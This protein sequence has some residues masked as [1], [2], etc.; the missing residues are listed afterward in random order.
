MQVHLSRNYISIVISPSNYTSPPSTAATFLVTHLMMV[1]QPSGYSVFHSGDTSYWT[2]SLVFNDNTPNQY[3]LPSQTSSYSLKLWP[4][5]R[6]MA[7]HISWSQGHSTSLHISE[8]ILQ[9]F[10]PGV[11]CTWYVS[12]KY[13]K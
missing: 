7:Q 2:Q 5:N 13:T 6:Q 4:C 8:S 9:T 1:S 10:T 12:K 11:N 3:L